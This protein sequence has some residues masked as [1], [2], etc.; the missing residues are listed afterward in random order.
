[1]KIA[2][3]MMPGR[4]DMDRLLSGLAEQ[5]DG[6]GLCVRGV[7]QSNQE[8]PGDHPCDMDVKVLPDGPELRISQALG[9]GSRG[10]RLDTSI[11]EKAAVTVEESL[12][13]EADLLLINK[14]GKHEAQGRGLA[15]AIAKAVELE[16]PVI[17]GLNELNKQAFIEF[18]GGEA[19]ALPPRLDAMVRWVTDARFNNCAA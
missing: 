6:A 9:K 14:F 12:E 8:R 4:G 16:V 10:C 7:V 3:T 5:L 17:C 18:T 13:P 11:L 2:Y 19:V 1:M 15:Q